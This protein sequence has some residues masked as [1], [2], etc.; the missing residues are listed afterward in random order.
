MTCAV[1][2][3]G[4][5]PNG[6]MLAGELC[7]AGLRPIVLER[8][9]ERSGPIRANGLVG[10]VV[11][12]LDYRGLLGRLS[13]G[14]PAPA[15]LQGYM[16]G[17]MPL[18]LRELEANPLYGLPVPQ[19]VLEQFLEE[20]ALELGAEIR[21]G[22]ELFGFTQDE[23]GV[24]I[25]VR[26]PQ[27]DY[28]LRGRYLVGCDG[29]SSTVRKLAGIGFPDSGEE[30]VVSR[31][32]DV[33]VPASMGAGTP[34]AA[35]R[36]EA[37]V[38]LVGALEVPGVGRVSFGFTRTSHGTFGLTSLEPGVYTIATLEWGRSSVDPSVQ[39]TIEEMRQSVRRVLGADIPMAPPRTPGTHRLHRLTGNSRQADCYRAG[40]ILLV[41]DAAHV[42]ATVG[43]PGLN[44]GLQDAVNLGWKL[45]ATVRGW[46]PPS[47]LDSYHAERHQVGSRVLMQTQAQMGLMAPGTAVTALR[48]MFTELLE[49][50]ANLRRIA[51]LMAGADIRY[52]MNVDGST[53]HPLAGRWVP[54]FRLITPT[55]ATRVAELM[56]AARP[57]VL[58]L[59]EGSGLSEGLGLADATMGW[60]DRLD[61]IVARCADVPSV[62]AA[63][64]IRPDGY[65]A[66]AA[67]RDQLGPHAIHELRAALTRWLGEAS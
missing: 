19:P 34:A 44:L 24:S 9:T 17:G 56:H 54:D 4:G 3:A 16:F 15:P 36:R 23:N 42:H 20:R 60:K 2:I 5:G 67:D 6:L 37:V 40:R 58:D 35:G 48:A 12:L 8:L 49:D 27:G 10:R 63:M 11:Q 61:L 50:T 28:H 22:H 55:G 1:V 41:G 45:A 39:M 47:L 21:R 32:A 31:G 51:E 30:E 64:L 13:A 18:D 57:V 29:A 7:L 52:D 65:V 53:P 33:V 26:G 38:P 66:W 25:E 59:T 14:A 43:G 62:P 46:A